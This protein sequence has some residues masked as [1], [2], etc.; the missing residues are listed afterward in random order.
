MKEG[1]GDDQGKVDGGAFGG[2]VS[3][4]VKTVELCKS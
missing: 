2:D 3:E 4:G 1:I